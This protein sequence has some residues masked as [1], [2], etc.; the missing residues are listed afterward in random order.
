[1]LRQSCLPRFIAATTGGDAGRDGQ[2]LS[3]SH[4]DIPLIASEVMKSLREGGRSGDDLFTPGE[5]LAF[6]IF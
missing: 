4:H 6:K 3:L 2:E 1:M 5:L